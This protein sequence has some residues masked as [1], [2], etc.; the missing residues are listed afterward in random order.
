MK[1][2]LRIVKA[3]ENEL[4]RLPLDV[5]LKVE[6][7]LA[8]MAQLAGETAEGDPLWLRKR[9]P[10]SGFLRF[11]L[12]GFCVLY[13]LDRAT[14]SVVVASIKRLSPSGCEGTL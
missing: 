1:Y 3:E 11:E 5:A 6:E 14:E 4:E 2:R 9:D 10:V 12:E 13:E 8:Q 7:H